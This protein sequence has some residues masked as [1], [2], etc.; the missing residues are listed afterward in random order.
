MRVLITGSRAPVALDLARQLAQAG[1]QV[2]MADSQRWPI[3]RFSKYIQAYHRLPRPVEQLAQFRECVERIV[4]ENKIDRIIP[5]C[6]E[7]FFF[8]EAWSKSGLAVRSPL[9]CLQKVHSKFQFARL[10]ESLLFEGV[11]S[12]ATELVDS[13]SDLERFLET[14]AEYVFKPVYSRFASRTLIRPSSKSL[15]SLVKPTQSDPWV[16][17]RFVEGK[18]YSTYCIAHQGRLAAIA[19]YHSIFKAGKGSGIYFVPHRDEPVVKFSAALVEKLQFTGQLGLDLIQDS[20]GKIWIL[21]GNPRATSGVHLFLAHDQLACSLLGLR[22]P[23]H[24]LVQPSSTQPI[25]LSFAMPF[26]GVKSAYQQG[27]LASFLNLWWKARD[28]V[29]Q[30]RDFAPTLGI[31]AALCELSWISLRE[32]CSLAQASTHDIEWNGEPLL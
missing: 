7:I 8:D 22:R 5:T 9:D 29:I 27:L 2:W 31:L 10:V 25:A 13:T 21:E 17:Q 19:C 20:Q 28:P 1:H 23:D 18:E 14:S 12:P 32:G 15:R 24:P 3:G 26:W 11:S 16:A 6:E 4:A 30:F